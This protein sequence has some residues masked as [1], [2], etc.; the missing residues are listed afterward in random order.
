M[1]RDGADLEPAYI[2]DDLS[3][4]VLGHF[5]DGRHIAKAPMMGADPLF[6]RPIK[7]VF[8]AVIVL[9]VR[10]HLF[11]VRKELLGRLVQL[12]L[13]SLGTPVQGLYCTLRLKG[14]LT[15]D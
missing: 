13:A 8:A 5:G 12:M 9:P 10:R 7:G 14:T 6:D 3:Q 1:R 15:S 4:L 2:G 11:F